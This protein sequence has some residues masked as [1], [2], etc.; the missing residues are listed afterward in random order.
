MA[1]KENDKVM[2][3]ETGEV[4]TVIL[5]FS[6]ELEYGIIVKESIGRNLAASE[7]RPAG[8]TRQRIDAGAGIVAPDP[9][10]SQSV[11]DLL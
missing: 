5:D 2:I 9:F 11:Q 6:D 7:V 8:H 4:V 3:V 1:Y 10:P